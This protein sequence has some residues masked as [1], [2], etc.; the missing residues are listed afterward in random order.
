MKIKLNKLATILKRA[1]KYE[2]KLFIEKKNYIKFQLKLTQIKDIIH[3]SSYTSKL[4]IQP[5]TVTT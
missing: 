2:A 3:N 4:T 1:Q 5:V